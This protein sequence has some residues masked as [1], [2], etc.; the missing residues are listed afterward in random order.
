MNGLTKSEQW[1]VDRDARRAAGHATANRPKP[2]PERRRTAQD[3]ASRYERKAYHPLRQ[4]DDMFSEL[5]PRGI[6]IAL[7]LKF[8]PPRTKGSRASLKAYPRGLPGTGRCSRLARPELLARIAD[9]KRF[10]G[11]KQYV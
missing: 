10:V 9:L 3:K 6:Q 8:G 11:V 5:S 2:L 7:R 1:R 4:L